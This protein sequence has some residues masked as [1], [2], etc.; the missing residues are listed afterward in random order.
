MLRVFGHD[1]HNCRTGFDWAYGRT[2]RGLGCSCGQPE[3]PEVQ[4]AR[5]CAA[6]AKRGAQPSRAA[7]LRPRLGVAGRAPSPRRV[8]LR[9]IA[10]SATLVRAHPRRR[11]R[12]RAG[13]DRATA[14]KIAD[15]TQ[16]RRIGRLMLEP[17]MYLLERDYGNFRIYAGALEAPRGAGYIAAVVVEQIRGDVRGRPLELYRD[18]E[19]AAGYR[20]DSPAEALTYATHL[21][22][23]RVNPRRPVDRR[24]DDCFVGAKLRELARGTPTQ[25]AG[26]GA[27]DPPAHHTPTR[28]P[29]MPHR[30]EQTDAF[31]VIDGRGRRYGMLEFTEF[32]DGY[33]L[34]GERRGEQTYRSYK[35]D[36]PA[37]HHRR[38]RHVH[39]GT[40]RPEAAAV[41]VVGKPAHRASA[42]RA[43]PSSSSRFSLTRD[44][45]PVL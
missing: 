33:V 19:L 37:L 16:R 28:W 17:A 41:G 21:A 14:P 42:T 1:K 22:M 4:R 20:W 35:L 32:V 24:A 13:A 27:D 39:R 6:G 43:P 31:D 36:A 34:N 12:R 40:D 23:L 8:G 26:R 25:C 11:R 29:S 30:A 9:A 3:C 7:R 38:R 18:D 15:R 5:R 2:V 44:D 10:R 45:E